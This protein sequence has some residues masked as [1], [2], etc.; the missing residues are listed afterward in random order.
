MEIEGERMNFT[1][2]ANAKKQTR[3]ISANSTDTKLF[4]IKTTSKK[5]Y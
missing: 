4:K 3:H 1:L 5:S 2:S